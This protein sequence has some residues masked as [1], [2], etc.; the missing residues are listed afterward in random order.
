M[1]FDICRTLILAVVIMGAG[2]GNL[3]EPSSFSFATQTDVPLSTN[4][5]SNVVTIKG[6]Q[7][8]APISFANLSSAAY[9][10]Y[11]INSGAFS[12]VQSSDQL[13]PGNTLQ[14]QQLTSS[15]AGA[16]RTTAINV[17]GRIV[18]FT[19]VTNSTGGIVSAGPDANGNTVTIS[20]ISASLSA[21][22]N[23]VKYSITASTNWTNNISGCT[24]GSTFP[25][26]FTLQ[27]VANNGSGAAYS[28]N[29]TQ[30]AISCGE[31]TAGIFSGSLP[32]TA[33]GGLPNAINGFPITTTQYWS[34][35]I[36]YWQIKAGSL[37]LQQ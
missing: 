34:S 21:V 22:N 6:N 4:I 13:F 18:T 3:T 15:V 20:N 28:T 7:F 17:G 25:V 8:G 11:S 26:A 24:S 19:T 30:V 32:T 35:L 2:C 10:Q 33:T 5:Q 9:S 27:A 37:T 23:V 1:K 31:Q 36:S 16:S 14:L 12:A 29:A